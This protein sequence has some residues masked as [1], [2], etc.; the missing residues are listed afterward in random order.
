MLKQTR[1]MGSKIA[2]YTCIT[3]GY[4]TPTDGFEKKEGFDYYLFSDVPIST[5]S[6]QNCIT[7]FNTDQISSVKK[8]RYIKTH[9]HI[10]L[11]D[12]DLVVWIDANTDIN[13]KLYK[14]IEENRDNVI[15]FKK[16]PDRDCI[17]EEIKEVVLRGKEGRELGESIYNLYTFK[18]F[19]TH[20]G[21]YETNVIVSHPKDER[22]QNLF[23][24]WW[25]EI[26]RGSHRDQLSLNYVIWK[27]KFSDFISDRKTMDFK[28]KFHRKLQ[29]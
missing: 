18:G 15:T 25:E 26:Y 8:Q 21:L 28:P 5:K 2:I 1:F 3:G 13:D 24:R 17:Y 12:Y 4:E 9:P 16:H 27:Y 6:W 14:Y 11:K 20:Y 23:E 7:N 29:K 19:P 10:V 22:V